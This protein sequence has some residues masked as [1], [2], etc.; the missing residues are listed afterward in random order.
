M[1]PVTVTIIAIV[2]SVFLLIFL[3]SLTK[4]SR[5]SFE[6]MEGRRGLF[7]WRG[8]SASFIDPKPTPIEIQF[9]VVEVAKTTTNGS[10]M[11]KLVYG[12]CS[13]AEYN[14]LKQV[15]QDFIKPWV[16]T[17]SVR[18]FDDDLTNES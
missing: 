17:N 8:T 13:G 15:R 14:L 11:S 18:W 2:A 12:P 10:P 9:E 6:D 16:E 1:D 7:I 4:K 5:I 3:V